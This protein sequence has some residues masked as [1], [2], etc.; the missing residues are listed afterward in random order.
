[1]NI[2]PP[3]RDPRRLPSRKEPLLVYPPLHRPYSPGYVHDEDQSKFLCHAGSLPSQLAEKS[4]TKKDPRLLRNKTNS[5]SLHLPCN[6]YQ[7]HHSQQQDGRV[8]IDFNLS[9]ERI[10][11]EHSYYRSSQ[12]NG[13]PSEP[14]SLEKSDAMKQ[15]SHF[16]EAGNL[17]DPQHAALPRHFLSP[18]PK[19][20][21]SKSS[22]LPTVSSQ[23]VSAVKENVAR[24]NMRGTTNVKSSS[25]DAYIQEFKFPTAPAVPV[26]LGGFELDLDT[27][28]ESSGDEVYASDEEKQK[29]NEVRTN[30]ASTIREANVMDGQPQIEYEPSLTAA[31]ANTLSTHWTIASS[32]VG[33]L[34]FKK[35][36]ALIVAKK[37]NQPSLTVE[38]LQLCSHVDS[39][40][41]SKIASSIVGGAYPPKTTPLSIASDKTEDGCQPT[42][43][44]K[45]LAQ[46]QE[47]ISESEEDDDGRDLD[48]AHRHR[49]LLVNMST[50]SE[51]EEDPLESLMSLRRKINESDSSRKRHT[52][53]RKL[54]VRSA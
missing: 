2:S 15:Q 5:Q 28:P 37:S 53:S 29:E 54:Q 45:R 49:Q 6:Q 18:L 12:H 27:E 17:S 23:S 9:L 38:E 30:K 25:Q 35:L 20:R 39:R 26:N 46:R 4:T 13:L 22:N 40:T 24:G 31:A 50:S 32:E 10:K 44:S 8:V 47:I 51:D 36:P 48:S 7:L 52:R 21:L 41:L 34:V 14:A 11:L 19:P 42:R 33:K 1:M 16:S 43:R 3:I